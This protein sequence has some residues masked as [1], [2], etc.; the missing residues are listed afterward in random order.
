MQLT[1]S[2]K[3]ILYELVKRPSS[4]D[5]EIAA[6][7]GIQRP[8][9]TNARHLF[10]R[11]K[12][13]RDAYLPDFPRIGC[14][15]L[16][17]RYGAYAPHTSWETRFKHTQPLLKNFFEQ[18]F[19]VINDTQR[20]CLCASKNFTELKKISDSFDSK[21]YNLGYYTQEIN[22][23]AYFPFEVSTIFRFL[24]FSPMLRKHFSMDDAPSK[25]ERQPKKNHGDISEN[26]QK[27]LLALCT[28]PSHSNREI[29]ET[30][31]LSER[32]ITNVKRR[33]VDRNLIR[34]IRIPDIRKLGFQL[35][36]FT[37]IFVHPKYPLV[38]RKAA[39]RKILDH[40][41]SF[42]VVSTDLEDVILSAYPSH[43]EYE[44]VEGDIFSHYREKGLLLK[45]W[46][47]RVFPVNQLRRFDYTVSP[48]VKKIFGDKKK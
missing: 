35:L 31:G 26:E 4:T 28:Y 9:V 16:A 36:I 8:T 39:I 46:E 25:K 18:F 32:T 14:E 40:E 12:A 27:T 5:G 34:F 2:R 23:N 43:E 48:L 24:D 29:G 47:E 38:K 37:R 44:L 41:Y 45:P 13:Y 22:S 33:L 11:E 30:I 21:I 1:Q 42:L 20:V 6:T 19:T 7:L 10:E 17:V 3:R 15:L